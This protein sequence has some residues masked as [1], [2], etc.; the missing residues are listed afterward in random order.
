MQYWAVTFG[1]SD[2]VRCSIPSGV[3][4][5]CQEEGGVMGWKE[6]KYEPKCRGRDEII[7]SCEFDDE[8]NPIR[9]SNIT[10][11]V[12]ELIPPS[13]KRYSPLGPLAVL[14]LKPYYDFHL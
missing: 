12:A 7:I 11:T 5:K 8:E 2:E 9:V 10:A 13:L 4:V 6:I 14:K 1:A 3:K